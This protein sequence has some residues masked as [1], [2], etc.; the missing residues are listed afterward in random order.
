MSF[1]VVIPSKTASNLLPCLAALRANEPSCPIVI[2]DDGVGAQGLDQAAFFEP[3]A[4]IPGRKPFNHST[5]SNIGIRDALECGHSAVLLNDDALLESP[6]GFSLMEQCCQLMPEIGLI[7]A[8]TNLTGQPLQNRQSYWRPNGTI[9]PDF[10]LRYVEHI[11]FVCVYLPATTLRLMAERSKTDPRFSVGLDERYTAYGSNDLDMCMQVEALGLR[12]AVQDGCFVDHAKLT[13]SYR[14]M[15]TSAGDIWPNHRLLRKKWNM[16]PNPQ[17][18]M[19]DELM[20]RYY[21]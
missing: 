19:Y 12:N 6:G 3:I 16:L 7:G 13:S 11:A 17:D 21:L 14:G 10:G 4:V 2:V 5:N 18:P 8:T 15:P 20:Q 1:Q 9:N